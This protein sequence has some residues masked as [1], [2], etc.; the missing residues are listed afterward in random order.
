MEQSVWNQQHREEHADPG[1]HHQG[2]LSKRIHQQVKVQHQSAPKDKKNE[3]L[4]GSG[5]SK[6]KN[7]L[8]NLCPKQKQTKQTFIKSIVHSS[9][10]LP[11][12][13]N[14]IY[15]KCTEDKQNEERNKHVVNGPDVIHLKK[16]A[17]KTNRKLAS[18]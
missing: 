3:K 2:E 8:S 4:S 5:L 13:I 10:L 1:A 11:A 16:L 14:E 12:F 7:D 18:I 15:H 9:L 17:R 6:F